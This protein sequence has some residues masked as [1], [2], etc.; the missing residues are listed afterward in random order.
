MADM[1]KIKLILA[2]LN[3]ASEAKKTA[4]GK[5]PVVDAP[6]KKSAE[7]SAGAFKKAHALSEK[8]HK[9]MKA[10][11]EHISGMARDEHEGAGELAKHSAKCMKAMSDLH[12]KVGAAAGAESDD[13]DEGGKEKGEKAMLAEAFEAMTAQGAQTAKLLTQLADQSAKIAQME[14]KLYAGKA[15]GPG[16]VSTVLRNG[17]IVRQPGNAS[18]K[19]TEMTD[20]EKNDAR[21]AALG[22]AHA[23]PIPLNQFHTTGVDVIRAAD[24]VLQLADSDG[25]AA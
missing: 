13:D 15:A 2:T 1:E 10:V 12:K 25:A 7:E 21:K 11:D 17:T 6:A 22:R 14:Q 3:A 8:A 9:A 20:E 24:K 19:V 4:T 5:E 16:A 18:K 23:M